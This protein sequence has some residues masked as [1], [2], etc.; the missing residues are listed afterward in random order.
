M[1][2]SLSTS[3]A[4]RR[5]QVRP[6]SNRKRA[7]VMIVGLSCS[8]LLLSVIVNAA[9]KLPPLVGDNMV[10]QRNVKTPVWGWATPGATIDLSFHGKQY[11]ATTDA[12]GKWQ[13]RLDEI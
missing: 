3:P 4:A 12:S 9:I 11:Q 13:L 7:I 1:K 6:L 10:L 2:Y 8:L 5:T